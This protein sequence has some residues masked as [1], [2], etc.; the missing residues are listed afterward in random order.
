[1]TWRRIFLRAALGALALVLLLALVGTVLAPRIVDTAWLR[2]T[3]A[4][5]LGTRLGAQVTMG[6]V[7]LALLPLPHAV[8]REVHVAIPG[9]VD[10][11][12]ESVSVYPRLR[13][14]ARAALQLG[15]LSLTAPTIEIRLPQAS[16]DARDAAVSPIEKRVADVL[17]GVSIAVASQAPT[18]TVQVSDARVAVLAADGQRVA[19]LEGTFSVRAEVDASGGLHAAIDAALPALKLSG[20]AAPVAVAHAS[21][22]T[23]VRLARDRIEI[24][25]EEVSLGHPRLHLSG[26]AAFD[27]AA[28]RATMDLTADDLD[29][30]SARAVMEMVP[31][32]RDLA[33][34]IFGVLREGRVPQLSLQASAPSV[35]ALGTLDALVIRGRLIEGLVRVPGPDIDLE[36]VAAAVSIE[37]GVLSAERAAARYGAS[38]AQ[39]GHLRLELSGERPGLRADATAHGDAADV[40]PLLKKVVNSAAL[41]RALDRMADIAGSADGTFAIDGPVDDPMPTVELSAFDVTGRLDGLAAPLRLTGGQFRYDTQAVAAS[42]VRAAT[43]GSSMADLS[44]RFE[45]G[46]LEVGAAASRLVLSELYPWIVASGW[47]P[48][49]S[50][51]PKAVAGTLALDSLRLSGPAATPS[52]WQVELA[53][54]F[55]KLALDAPSLGD[56]LALRFPLSIA[57]FRLHRDPS[58]IS[59][60]GRVTAAGGVSARFAADVSDRGVHVKQLEI[61]GEG[62]RASLVLQRGDGELEVTFKGNLNEAAANALLVRNRP[63]LGG[64]VRGDFHVRV[65]PQD[66]GQSVAEGQLEAERVF[67]PLR[68]GVRLEIAHLALNA[69]P[70]QLAVRAALDAGGT[71]SGITVDG[72]ITRSPQALTVDAD[73][74]AG[75]VDGDQLAQLVSRTDERAERASSAGWNAPLRGTV[76][77]VA[78]SFALRGYTW[79]PFRGEVALLADGPTLTVTEAQVCG[80][81]TPGT[82]A[83][84]PQGVSVTVRPRAQDQGLESS[85]ACLTGESERVTGTFDLTGTVTATGNAA[86]LAQLVQGHVEVQATNGRVYRMASVAKA[87]S[88]I[89]IASGSIGNVAKMSQEGLPFDRMTLKGDLRRSVLAFSEAVLDGPT[90]KIAA[91][92]SLDFAARTIDAVFLVAPLKTVDSVVSRLPVIGTMLGGSLV[93]VPVAVKGP[94]GDPKVTPL[95]PSA[96]GSELVG[97]MK[98]TVNLPLRVMQPLWPGGKHR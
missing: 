55:E 36:D 20:G 27:R 71:M 25:V 86:D 78:E 60:S 76:R 83:V 48:E 19:D 75:H 6:D 23:Q 53:G 70:G 66:P 56:R 84:A 14:L 93:S 39:D 92:G 34:E 50:A 87:L 82:V 69:E 21:I 1:M 16:A 90:V 10:A 91:T 51:A 79:K 44:V 22:E 45:R 52:A 62:S 15:R 67:L 74:T 3:V 89:S 9:R 29:V 17:A 38:R 8:L 80:I 7:R 5:Q 65:D 26:H 40:V 43:G 58:L 13:S 61:D 94:L 37:H 30:A 96:I 11:A 54:A 95:S 47:A 32:G 31:G 72:R 18:L 77:V 33:G 63:L 24:D 12:V 85:L 98:R 57:D 97:I 42:G 59:T 49:G 46:G 68:D 81:A 64:W 2:T 73:V 41:R 4:E 88:A 35:A 28:P